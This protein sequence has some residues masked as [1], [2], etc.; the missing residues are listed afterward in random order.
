[1]IF[2]CDLTHFRFKPRKN[3][4]E[5]SW[6]LQEKK[7][8]K[9]SSLFTGYAKI[10]IPI[11][12]SVSEHQPTTWFSFFFDLHILVCV[13]PVG[14]WLCIKNVNDERVFIILYAVSAVYFAGVM[15]RLMLTL[16]PCVCILAA[17]GKISGKLFVTYGPSLYY[18]SKKVGGGGDKMRMWAKKDKK[19]HFA[20]ETN[21]GVWVSFQSGHEEML[22]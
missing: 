8:N 12:A 20:I 16:T 1:M 19:I 13:F 14:L 10:H 3:A 2:F 18:V 4:S 9:K 15:V 11:I 6:P 7:T 17:I 22:T 5:I 21:I